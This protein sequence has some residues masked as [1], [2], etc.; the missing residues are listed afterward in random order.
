MPPHG[1][2]AIAFVAAFCVVIPLYRRSRF[3]DTS[4]IVTTDRGALNGAHDGRESTGAGLF[5]RFEKILNPGISVFA[6][7]VIAVASMQLYSEGAAALLHDGAAALQAGTR[8]SGM[9]PIAL[10]LLA[11]SYPIVDI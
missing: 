5:T 1:T 2:L 3:F 4:A 11:L 10:F 6:V 9:R 7:L 8:P